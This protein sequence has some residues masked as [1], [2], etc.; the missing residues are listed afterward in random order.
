M[1]VGRLRRDFGSEDGKRQEDER[2]EEDILIGVVSATDSQ[3]GDCRPQKL[4]SNQRMWPSVPIVGL[5]I[6]VMY[7]C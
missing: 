6:S 1:T 4:A 3:I 5:K 7:L 2:S